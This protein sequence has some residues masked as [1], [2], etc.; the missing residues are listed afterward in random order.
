MMKSKY[1][2]AIINVTPWF[3][4]TGC[5]F[6]AVKLPA[7]LLK[8]ATEKFWRLQATMLRL[9]ENS[10]VMKSILSLAVSIK[11]FD[12]KEL[13]QPLCFILNLQR[14]VYLTNV[15]IF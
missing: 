8:K 1:T 12:F 6:N 10:C 5:N 9:N 14:P 3:Y 11:V 2:V 13:A 4:H 7:K 15:L